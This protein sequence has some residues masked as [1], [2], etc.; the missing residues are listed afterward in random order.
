MPHG[1]YCASKRIIYF[2]SKETKIKA[3]LNLGINIS[4]KYEAIREP[5]FLLLIN[6]SCEIAADSLLPEANLA[7]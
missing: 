3:F 5:K 1:Q 2:P 6:I 4:Y 7:C